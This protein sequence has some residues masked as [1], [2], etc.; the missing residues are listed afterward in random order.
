MVR[1][2]ITTDCSV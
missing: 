2:Q 1:V